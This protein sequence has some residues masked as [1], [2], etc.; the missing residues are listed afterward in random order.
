MER[1]RGGKVAGL[2][3]DVCKVCMEDLLDF[4]LGNEMSSLWFLWIC[5]I[6]LLYDTVVSVATGQM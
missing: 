4:G 1:W 3:L 5:S 6:L 2:V